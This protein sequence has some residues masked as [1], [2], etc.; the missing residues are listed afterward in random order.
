MDGKV[1][2]TK[3]LI[4]GQTR[5]STFVALQPANRNKAEGIV[6]T[7]RNLSSALNTQP[8]NRKCLNT[9]E[10]SQ[11]QQECFHKN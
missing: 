8:T 3:L 9:N 10:T 2:V 6:F 1:S 4:A 11:Q 5:L 7:P